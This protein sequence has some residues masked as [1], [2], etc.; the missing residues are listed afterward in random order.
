MSAE[1]AE[2]EF[3]F[4]QAYQHLTG[5]CQCVDIINIHHLVRKHVGMQSE[6]LSSILLA[7]EFQ[8]K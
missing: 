2:I 1:F 4:Q 7:Q 8:R 5:N 3:G 6:H